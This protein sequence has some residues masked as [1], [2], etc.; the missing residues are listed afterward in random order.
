V[1]LTIVERLQV[2]KL[3]PEAPEFVPRHFFTST[4][5]TDDTYR[6]KLSQRS[7]DKFGKEKEINQQTEKENLK[8]QTSVKKSADLRGQYQIDCMRRNSITNFLSYP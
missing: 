7:L 2:P 4:D 1:F 5:T 8:N 3:K 6:V